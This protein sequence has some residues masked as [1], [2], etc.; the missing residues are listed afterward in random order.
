M[1]P[2]ADPSED[3]RNSKVDTTLPTDLSCPQTEREV[4][5]A[6]LPTIP[7]VISYTAD[8]AN[9]L[10]E[11]ENLAKLAGGSGSVSAKSADRFIA[12]YRAL[13]D[14]SAVRSEIAAVICDKGFRLQT[15]IFGACLAKIATHFPTMCELASQILSVDV[16]EQRK[17]RSDMLILPQLLYCMEQLPGDRPGDRADR[18]IRA[19]EPLAK[20]VLT[21]MSNGVFH[22]HARYASSSR[23]SRFVEGFNVLS[24][25]PEPLSSALYAVVMK[26]TKDRKLASSALVVVEEAPISFF[27]YRS[28]EMDLNVA[29]LAIELL[30]NARNG[31]EQRKI[32]RVICARL[33]EFHST[34]PNTPN[35]FTSPL[36]DMFTRLLTAQP[37]LMEGSY[38]R[39]KAASTFVSLLKLST[40]MLRCGEPAA[41]HK[42]CDLVPKRFGDF[43]WRAHSATSLENY[44]SV[45]AQRAAVVKRI[46]PLKHP[47]RVRPA[48]IRYAVEALEFSLEKFDTKT[49]SSLFTK[50]IAPLVLRG[51]GMFGRFRKGENILESV[52]QLAPVI[53]LLAGSLPESREC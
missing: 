48:H 10:R 3:R 9:C 12:L 31:H 44:P 11:L 37:H 50:H 7:S 17:K 13:P 41:F 23:W 15:P 53:S 40:A 45:D 36:V 28:K 38:N 25:L 43:E 20:I 16:G 47:D 24:A 32:A 4:Q 26:G 21:V 33:E 27:T 18:I 34:F 46:Q 52:P 22:D 49:R 35:L 39:S 30:F 5:T 1:S 19:A 6:S 29:G 8:E 42:L 51:S 14:N 2:A